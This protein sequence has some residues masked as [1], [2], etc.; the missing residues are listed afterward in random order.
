M[1][2]LLHVFSRSRDA[3]MMRVLAEL[4][5]RR[6]HRV[7]L[8]SS[9]S[10]GFLIRFW[11]PDLLFL[12]NPDTLDGFVEQGL[13]SPNSGPLVGMFPQEGMNFAD[14]D[15]ERWYG[16]FRNPDYAAMI[17]RI[18]LWNSHEYDW[19]IA[20]TALEPEQVMVAGGARMDIVRYSDSV[21]KPNTRSISA[22]SAGLCLP[23]ARMA[24]D[25]KRSLSMP[26]AFRVLRRWRMR[27]S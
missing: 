16:R 4:L 2:I 23:T 27:S 6:G 12:T 18:F 17:D 5:R 10:I 19:L 8:A 15:K 3:A 24:S 14:R 13:V 21:R 26:P 22:L 11:R 20:N 7:A 9:P 25:W 1:K